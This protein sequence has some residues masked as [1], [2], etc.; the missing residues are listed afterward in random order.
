MASKRA[1]SLSPH[2]LRSLIPDEQRTW[3]ALLS[4]VVL[5]IDRLDEDLQRA[6]GMSHATYAVL[7]SLSET[8]GRALRLGQLAAILWSPPT[9]M[10]YLIDQIEKRGWVRREVAPGDRRGLLAVLTDDGFAALERAAPLH[11]ESVRRRVFD[12]LDALA[13]HQLYSLCQRLLPGLVEPGASTIIDA[14]AASAAS[15]PEVE[16]RIPPPGNSGGYRP[17]RQGRR[18]RQPTGS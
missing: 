13:I 3:R 1:P 18:T 4:V 9:R 10:T 6:A 17:S 15:G 7:A 5:L 14:I 2:Q 11:L 12:Q 8:P 16:T